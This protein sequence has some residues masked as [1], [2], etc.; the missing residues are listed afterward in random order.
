MRIVDC[1]YRE[2]LFSLI[3]EHDDEWVSGNHTVQLQRSTL[4]E[5][6]NTA[7][8][9]T[10]LKNVQWHR[11]STEIQPLLA[12]PFLAA[13]RSQAKWQLMTILIFKLNN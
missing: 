10:E 9:Q 1:V 12:V 11:Q 4:P 13:V 6:T 2:Y 8:S 5:L 7:S 3:S